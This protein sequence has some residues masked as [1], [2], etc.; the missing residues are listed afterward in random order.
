M[1]VELKMTADEQQVIK[2]L[3]ASQA[4][5]AKLEDKIK[6]L[7]EQLRK[8]GKDS[9]DT[10]GSKALNSLQNYAASVV[11]VGAVWA[12]TLA[13]MQKVREENKQLSEGMKG[14]EAG[15][16]RLSQVSS[17]T[18]EFESL[19]GTTKRVA[20]TEG[21]GVPRAADI[22]FQA[23]SQG[24]MGDL[25]AL[26]ASSRFTD[27]EAMIASVGKFKAAFGEAESGN[28]AALMSKFIQAASSSDVAIEDIARAAVVPAQAARSIGTTD[29]ELLGLISTLSPAFK[30]PETAATRLQ[31]LATVLNRGVTRKTGR[32]VRDPVTRQLVD[33]EQQIQFSDRGILGG[34]AAFQSQFPAEFKQA[35]LQSVE[36]GAAASA[37]TANL[38]TART[39][40][41]EVTTAGVSLAPLRQQME[42]TST[43]PL[44]AIRETARA[45]VAAELAGEDA[46]TRSLEYERERARF[47]AAGRKAG[48]FKRF[49]QNLSLAGYDAE[50]AM[51]GEDWATSRIRSR[52]SGSE[53]AG[54]SI[55][56]Q[57][58]AEMQRQTQIMEQ[59]RGG[60]LAPDELKPGGN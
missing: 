39:R 43:G 32:K 14:Q 7:N 48:G 42:I 52:F 6:S 45:N 1:A 53:L 51:F 49:Y 44:A 23:K 46:A 54:G 3:G 50:A 8:G 37:I 15:L 38:G 47:Q 22:V 41:A 29:E 9:E 30:S 24:L 19:V 26:A 10:F 5:V 35:M 18:S 25:P 55:A 11:S 60:T 56:D 33:E 16:K 20:L 57:M 28:A 12:A 13:T 36:A 31:T 17:S 21:L 58:L 34:M 2:A 40:V 27:A 4:A 59:E